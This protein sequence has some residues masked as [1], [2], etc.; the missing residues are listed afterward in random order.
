MAVCILMASITWMLVPEGVVGN[1]DAEKGPKI[2]RVW[3]SAPFNTVFTLV[4]F[5]GEL[6]AAG[7]YEERIYRSPDGYTWTPAFSQMTT[8]AW[9]TSTVYNGDLYFSSTEEHGNEY[10]IDVWR[11]SDGIV[12]EHVYEQRFDHFI[13]PSNFGEFQEALYLAIKDGGSIIRS[14]DGENW[15]EVYHSETYPRVKEFI[16]F[17]GAFYAG[18]YSRNDGGALLRT[19]DGNEWEIVFTIDE[20]QDTWHSAISTFTIFKDELYYGMNDN[21][22]TKWV[23]VHRSPDG[24]NFTEVWYT[25]E[26]GLNAPKLRVFNDRLYVILSG[27][28]SSN[29]GGAIY[30]QDDGVFRLLKEGDDTYEHSFCEPAILGNAMYVGSGS[31]VAA[32][33][34]AAVY[35]I[36]EIDCKLPFIEKVWDDAPFNTI[37]TLCSWNDELYAA[38]RYDEKIYRSSDGVEWSEAFDVITTR[39][40]DASI[41]YNGSIYFASTE[42][43]TDTWNVVFWRSTDGITLEKVFE[44]D[45]SSGKIYA[46]REFSIINDTLMMSIKGGPRGVIMM[47]RN[48]TDWEEFFSN[49]DYRYLNDLVEFKGAYYLG[50]A[51]QRGGGALFQSLDAVNWTIIRNWTDGTRNWH[52]T[53]HRMVVFEDELYLAL[54]GNKEDA[55]V[56]ILKTGDGENF[57]KVW[58][59]AEDE[60][61]APEFAVYKDKLYLT[62]A[63]NSS[64]NEGG[65]IRIFTGTDF[66]LLMDGDGDT[67]HNFRGKAIFNDDLYIGGG[68]GKWGTGDAVLYRIMDPCPF[69]TCSVGTNPQPGGGTGEGTGEGTDEGTDE[70]TGEGTGGGT[71]Y[72]P[73]DLV[74]VFCSSSVSMDVTL[75]V[76]DPEGVSRSI[77]PEPRDNVGKNDNK[78]ESRQDSKNDSNKNNGIHLFRFRIGEDDPVGLWSVFAE[79]D[80]YHI[81]E[82]ATF[83]VLKDP[84]FLSDPSISISSF[85]IPSSVLIGL[86]MPVVFE[87]V[88]TH[89]TSVDVLLAVQMKDPDMRS[90][91]PV[92]L[93]MTIPENSIQNITLVVKIP[94]AALPGSYFL[95]GQMHVDYPRDAGHVLDFRTTTV[96]VT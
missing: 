82:K 80:R 62:M 41:V 49:E 63:G 20:G 8:Y 40:W 55:W 16:E 89:E 76:I 95:Q 88:N 67:E 48:G 1:D 45:P 90:L 24:E 17:N 18:A 27:T 84:P 51:S 92:T 29:I 22:D 75:T 86:S 19:L 10:S 68:S 26:T 3:N 52:N 66:E 11:S 56:E 60:Y 7:R 6:Y 96:M 77:A 4:T 39:A 2:E 42:Q 83:Q 5:Q 28:G 94:S 9:F 50:T 14:Y 53:V 34:D 12:L 21:K 33:H 87:I 35:R 32:R 85:T 37:Y 71:N 59:G 79:N 46:H 72:K 61:N 81:K 13:H 57:T 38:G 64:T 73:G 30:Y 78:N 15:E 93:E 43:E 25:R 74:E 54:N 23:S 44:T 31:S 69:I 47:S 36:S 91:K 65:E 70:G 58:Q